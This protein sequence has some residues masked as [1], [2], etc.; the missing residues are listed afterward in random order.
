MYDAINVL[1]KNLSLI[2]LLTLINEIL[3]LFI[4]IFAKIKIIGIILKLRHA[5]LQGQ[6]SKKFS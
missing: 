1:F 4:Q 5:F 3:N 2:T 6:G